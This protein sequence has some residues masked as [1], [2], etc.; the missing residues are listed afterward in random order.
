MGKLF[1]PDSGLMKGLSMVG[2]LMLLNFL[3]I[4]CCIPVVTIGAASAAMYSVTLKIAAREERKIVKPFFSAFKESFLRA[5]AMW[6]IFLAAGYLITL[7]IRV[8]NANPN[9][10]PWVFNVVYALAG[11]L[12]LIVMSW[13]W[14]LEARFENSVGHTLKNALLLGLTHP[15]ISLVTAVLTVLPVAFAVFATYWFLV[16][17][18]IWF[19]FGF[20][21]IAMV[22]SL[23]F[24]RVF[25]KYYYQ[26]GQ[27]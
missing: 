8:I 10:L 16:S 19:L 3:Y 20:S 25:K 22:N 9:D 4:L 26:E 7:G 15:F 6:L 21:C 14:P 11:I 17:S 23:L 27:S 13:S 24:H 18:I 2:D 1:H 12:L 5:T